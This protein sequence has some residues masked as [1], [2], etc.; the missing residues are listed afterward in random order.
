MTAR[1][2]V[3]DDQRR[4]RLALR[5]GLTPA[6]R[7]AGPAQVADG[8][9]ALHATDTPTIHLS[10]A[11]R[12]E[13]STL[14]DTT[15]ALGEGRQ[16]HRQLAMRRTQWAATDEVVDLMLPGPSAR[17]AAAERRGLFAELEASGVTVDGARWLRRARADVLAAL[18]GADLT[19]AQLATTS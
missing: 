10:I 7:F 18:D 6:A 3:G 5:H 15:W 11:A 1:P 19:A 14:A 4:A 8:L 16:L 13:G 2:H 9:V 12:V 17:V